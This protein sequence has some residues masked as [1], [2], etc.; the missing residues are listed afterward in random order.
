MTRCSEATWRNHACRAPYYRFRPDFNF[1]G[2]ERKR[3]R[4]KLP[5]RTAPRTHFFPA[6]RFAC[7]SSFSLLFF[8]IRAGDSV[9]RG[10]TPPANGKK[11]ALCINPIG[12]TSARIQRSLSA[13]G[14]DVLRS[15]ITTWGSA[16]RRPRSLPF[17]TGRVSLGLRSE[18]R[19]LFTRCLAASPA[20]AP[21]GAKLV[22][23][24]CGVVTLQPARGHP[25]KRDEG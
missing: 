24:G 23:P 15:A 16:P 22:T 1:L 5:L 8:P 19:P 12:T 13:R 7:S 25:Q 2:G 17:G 21:Q 9:V 10:R 4:A 14:S 18:S 6:C 11:C 20:I 3:T